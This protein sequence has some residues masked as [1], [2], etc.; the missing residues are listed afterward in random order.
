MRDLIKFYSRLFKS[1]LQQKKKQKY[2]HKK[3]KRAGEDEAVDKKQ[4]ILV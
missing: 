1:N 2:F 3:L 4:Q